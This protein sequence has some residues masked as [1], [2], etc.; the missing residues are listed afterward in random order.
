MGTCDRTRG[1]CVCAAGFEGLACERSA[2]WFGNV[3]CKC[4]RSSLPRRRV[5]PGWPARCYLRECFCFVRWA[6]VRGLLGMGRLCT[7][8]CPNA[9][10]GHGQCLSLKDV[11]V[12]ANSVPV[13]NVSIAYDGY[14]VPSQR[15][16]S[17]PS[18]LAVGPT[19]AFVC[20]CLGVLR[21]AVPVGCHAVNAPVY[22]DVG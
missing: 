19:D 6:L 3:M 14:Q 16:V 18:G 21:M 13:S 9:C 11:S 12:A 5:V 22:V 4:C 17:A 15:T 10:S 8:S 2:S 7:A 1:V 20:A